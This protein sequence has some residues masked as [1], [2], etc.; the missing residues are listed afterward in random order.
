MMS[1]YVLHAAVIIVFCWG[2]KAIGLFCYLATILGDVL[3]WFVG[4]LGSILVGEIM[5]HYLPRISNILL[6]GR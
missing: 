6:G 2:A 4:V 3:M 5:R 1:V